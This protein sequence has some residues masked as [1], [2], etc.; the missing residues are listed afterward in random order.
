MGGD[1]MRKAIF[2]VLILAVLLCSG[3][4]YFQE[5]ADQTVV[6]CDS[7]GNCVTETFNSEGLYYRY[8]ALEEMHRKPIIALKAKEGEALNLGNIE[9]LIVY[10]R[11]MQTFKP[12]ESGAVKAFREWGGIAGNVLNTGLLLWGTNNIADTIGKHAGTHITRSFNP[13]GANSPPVY[14]P[15]GTTNLQYDRHDVNN[16]HNTDDSHNTDSHDDNSGQGEQ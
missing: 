5:K 14:S 3:C 10:G 7:K 12:Y 4:S 9:S 15:N 6:T 16:S 1:V 2:I 13:S 8:Q 11:K